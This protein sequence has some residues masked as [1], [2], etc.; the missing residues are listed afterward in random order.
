VKGGGGGREGAKKRVYRKKARCIGTWGIRS[1]I[2]LEEKREES[3]KS[4]AGG[5]LQKGSWVRKGGDLEKTEAFSSQNS[6]PPQTITFTDYEMKEGRETIQTQNS[7]NC[8]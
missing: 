4:N 2:H 3:P 5:E 8:V 1:K 7:L 6:H